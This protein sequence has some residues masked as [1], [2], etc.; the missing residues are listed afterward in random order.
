MLFT[1]EE[2]KLLEH[3][4]PLII[5]ARNFAI[6]AHKDQMYGNHPYVYHL[7]MTFSFVS[8]D[9]RIEGILAYLHDIL[10]DTDIS[11]ND[12]EKRFGSIVADSVLLLTDEPGINRKERKRKTNEKLSKSSNLS[13][14]KVKAA[15]RL[16]NTTQSV[17]EN[18]LSKIK[19]Y[20]KEY[21]DFKK[22]VFRYPNS[23][24][25][26]LEMYNR[27]LPHCIGGLK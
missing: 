2:L 3:T 7:D 9:G 22:A 26:T 19:M 17:I 11:Y 18:N 1:E 4:N 6:N 14:L 25:T 13:A 12:I 23:I 21:D 8:N 16:A 5:Y 24:W 20:L 27:V 15:D 10:E